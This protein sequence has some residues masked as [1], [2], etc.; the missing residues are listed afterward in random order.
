M[1]VATDVAARGLHIRGLPYVVNYDF[2]GNLEQYIHRW[3]GTGVQCKWAA[4]PWWLCVAAGGVLCWAAK[5]KDRI[6]SACCMQAPS[7]SAPQPP[8]RPSPVGGVARWCE[9]QRRLCLC[10]AAA[11]SCACHRTS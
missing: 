6:A 7:N 2:P 5:C 8:R 4:Q 10:A 1:L 11:L 9:Q 3:G